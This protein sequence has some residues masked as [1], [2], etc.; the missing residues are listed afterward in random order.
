MNKL[1]D[2]LSER[3][4]N[5]GDFT[6]HAR[7]TQDIKRLLR[8]NVNNWVDM[9][10]FQ[11]EALDMIAHKLARIVNGNPNHIDSWQDIAGYAI[12][13]TERIKHE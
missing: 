8:S 12:L 5:Y 4:S 11:R 9:E 13:V 7:I 3:G 6:D 10:P 1:D 2:V